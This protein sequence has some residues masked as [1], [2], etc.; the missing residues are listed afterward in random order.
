MPKCGRA[1]DIKGYRVGEKK[2][3]LIVIRVNSNGELTCSKP[4]FNCSRLIRRN[5]VFINKIY[6]SNWSGQ[7]EQTTRLYISSEWRSAF[8]KHRYDKT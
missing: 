3:N 8:N 6:Y 7:I 5:C 2:V 1:S 4:C